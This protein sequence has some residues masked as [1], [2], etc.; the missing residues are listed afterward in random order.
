MS[1]EDGDFYFFKGIS[2]ESAEIEMEVPPN[3]ESL[4]ELIVEPVAQESWS[5][6]QQV[7]RLSRV[8]T[9]RG[10][11]DLQSAGQQKV[12]RCLPWQPGRVWLA[13]HSAFGTCIPWI[14]KVTLRCDE[15]VR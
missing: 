6:E 12:W 10:R 14:G 7:S 11:T 13:C 4:V 2:P 1:L 9:C 15:E 5:W 8:E 3:N